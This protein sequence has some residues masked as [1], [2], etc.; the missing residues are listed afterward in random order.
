[1][2]VAIVV[3][4]NATGQVRTARA[5][6]FDARRWRDRSHTGGALAGSALKPSSWARLRGRADP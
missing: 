5:D 2:S 3:V 6:Y 1:M 4:E